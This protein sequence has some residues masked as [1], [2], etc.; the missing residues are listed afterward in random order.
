MS[1][2]RTII[3]RVVV[4]LAF[5]IVVIGLLLWL[6]GV[7]EPKIRPGDHV[8]A[9]ARRTLPQ[10]S[11]TIDVV[12]RTIPGSE[13]A[14]GTIEAQRQTTVA[15]R[16]L[17]RVLA[18]SVEAGQHVDEGDLLVQ[19]DDSDLRQRLEQARSGM[20]A[21][22]AALD[23]AT[24][25]LVRTERSAEAAAASSFELIRVRNAVRAAQAELDRAQQAVAEAETIL[26]YSTIVAPFTGIVIERRAEVGD[27]VTPGSPLLTM[28]DPARM[29]LV[30]SVR[31][32]LAVR[33]AV[34]DDVEAEIESLGLRC[35]A[36]V[37]EI[38]P[39]A[40]AQSRSFRIKVTG[41]CPPGVYPGMF[42]RLYLPTAE[43]RV[44]AIPSS[45]IREVGQISLVDVV[46]TD[47]EGRLLERRAIQ[48]GRELPDGMTEVLAGLKAGERIA[49]PQNAE[50]TR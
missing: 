16:I 40:S 44:V 2:V 10:A 38:V 22:T 34:G 32:S 18:T 36:E 30:A 5:T 8:E 50:P 11:P 12:E 46:S 4:G 9:A 23:L 15:S 19:L 31:E 33:V 13:S 14:V 17:S 3:G 27:T 45:A 47:A 21:R 37:A 41:P 42:G 43:E 28:Y 7:F 24:E 48:L 49:A 25:E 29:Q 20:D 1:R 26:A 6:A 35:R 39:E